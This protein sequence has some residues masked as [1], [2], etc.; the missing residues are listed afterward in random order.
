M[1]IKI[2]RFQIKK[3]IGNA[4][5]EKSFHRHSSNVMSKW[6]ICFIV[7]CIICKFVG[8]GYPS[9]T[10]IQSNTERDLRCTV[11]SLILA[12]NQKIIA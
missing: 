7:L 5:N 12:E 8:E 4:V 10:S 2:I 3:G 11:D 1:K 9:F 6:Q